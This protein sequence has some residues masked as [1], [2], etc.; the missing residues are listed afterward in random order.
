MNKKCT[1]CLTDQDTNKFYKSKTTKDG[2]HYYCKE[3]DAIAAKE[4]RDR[5]R[6]ELNAYNRRYRKDHKEELKAKRKI[7]YF[8]SIACNG[9]DNAQQAAFRKYLEERN[10]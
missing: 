10:I 1:K 8:H 9:V 6:D 7:Y 5:H 4:Y 2:R 3:C